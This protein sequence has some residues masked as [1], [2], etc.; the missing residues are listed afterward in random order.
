IPDFES[1]VQAPGRD[2]AAVGA[3]GQAAHGRGV[4]AEHQEFLASL[5]V[6]DL[7]V[8]CAGDGDQPGEGD[9]AT[10]RAEGDLRVKSDTPARGSD[11]PPGRYFPDLQLTAGLRLVCGWVDGCTDRCQSPTV[12]AQG[13]G[14]DRCRVAKECVKRPACLHVPDL[15]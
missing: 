6:P 4:T 1:P 13:D 3:E 2:A 14:T 5:R 12:S 11:F 9:A 7:H 10:I 15:H 8:S